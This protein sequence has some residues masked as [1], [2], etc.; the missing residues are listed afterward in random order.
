LLTLALA[1]AL[2]GTPAAAGN[3]G[4]RP[5]FG[6]AP[7]LVVFGLT[8]D[9]RL[10]R[11]RECN[12]ER[13]RDVG[14]ITGLTGSDTAL[15]G[16]DFRVQ[17]GLLYGVGNGGGVYQIDTVTAVGTKVSQLTETLV[18]A[19]FGVDFNPAADRLRIV[20]ET[21]QQNLRHNINM[22]GTTIVDGP[23]AY[24]AGMPTAGVT[25][26]AYTNNDLDP[27]TGTTLL[28]LD[29]SLDQIALQSP[30]NAGSLALIGKLTV[31]AGVAAGFDIY[32]VL[33]SGVALHNRGFAVIEA[34]GGSGFYRV[35]LLTGQ[36][37]L[38]GELADAMIDL[39]I[40]LDQ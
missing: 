13:A 31:D 15:V 33:R 28:D 40:P 8:A 17:D 26:A 20:S 30:P 19:S 9:Q 21:G 37:I 18:G 10:V 32:T 7:R 38:I 4:D 14:A 24:T 1:A 29:T 5:A 27:N 3:C 6:K 11:F 35:N 34:G 23:L 2:R 12:P 39:A 25:G 16:I 36:A 22:G